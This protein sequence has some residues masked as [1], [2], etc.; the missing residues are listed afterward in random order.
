MRVVFACAGTGGHINPA[1]AIARKI[2]KEEKDSEILFIG[3]FDGL[4]NT[5]VKEAGFNI[6]PIRTGKLRRSLS[7][8]NIS[9]MYRAFRGISDAKNILKEFKPD[10]VIGTGGYICIPV[11]NA[12]KALN[13]PYMLHESNAFPGVSVKLLSK[14]ASRVFIAFEDARRRLKNRDNIVLSGTPT[15]FT[16]QDYLKLDVD[17][18]KKELDIN[19]NKKVM[20]VTGGSQGA[21][22]FSDIVLN[23]VACTKIDDLYVVLITGNKNYDDVISKKKI[24]EEKIGK[25]LDNKIKIIKFVYEMEKMYRVADICMCRS[26]ALTITELSL[27]GKPSILIPFPYATENHQFYN[28]K[29]L[30]DAG[31]GIIINESEVSSKNLEASVKN[32]LKKDSEECM[33]QATRIFKEDVQDI[34]YKNILEVIK[35]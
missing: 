1:I 19:T 26:G 18:C 31:L 10:V 6:K 30:E 12:A 4:E 8:K 17:E 24:L 22:V 7:P 23:F 9:E 33:R 32:L 29:V 20:L 27:V 28:A 35:K 2:V 3:T 14:N 15:K 11:M 21:K 34:I 13:I 5:L 25:S 16:K